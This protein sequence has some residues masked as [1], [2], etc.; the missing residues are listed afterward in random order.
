MHN[1]LIIGFGIVG[2]NLYNE[3]KDLEPD[4]VDKYKPLVNTIKNIKYDVGFICVDTPINNGVLD[5]SEVE[6]CLNEYD[7]D[8]Y[9]I[10]STCPVGTVEKLINKTN[11]RIIFSPE[12]YGNTKHCNNYEF[13]F[14]ILGGDKKDCNDVIQILMHCYDARHLFRIVEPKLAELVKF[15][16]NSFL[17]T[18]VSFCQSFYEICEKEKLNYSELRE[19]FILDPRVNKSHTFVYEETP[20]W[21]SHCL[22]KDVPSIAN[23]YNNLF[24]QN[25]IKFNNE[26]KGM[27]SMDKWTEL[28]EWIEKYYKDHSAGWIDDTENDRYCVAISCEDLLEKMKKLEE[29][30]GK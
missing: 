4:V 1:I 21:N 20:Y 28:R 13:N 22:N 18:K 24:L 8:I 19:L 2:Q 7:C 23:Q 10:K 30:L 15:M 11:K 17:A 25:V 16:E 12:Y 29:K 3:I 27:I 26:Q 5:I 9:C 6:N 14:T